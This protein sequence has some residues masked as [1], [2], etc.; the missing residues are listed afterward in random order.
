MIRIS[1]YPIMSGEV[2]F[3][4]SEFHI[5]A[6]KP[7]QS[8]ILETD[9]IHHKS[10]ATVDQNYLEFLIPGD[11]ETYIDLDIKLLVRG[12]LIGADGKDL[13]AS[14]FTAGTNN[15]LHSLLIVT[16]R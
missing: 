16:S 6:H 7:L 1:H 11:S 3:V 13:D 9:V 8:A 10:I 5:F 2:E 15:F 12:R 14:G 4:S